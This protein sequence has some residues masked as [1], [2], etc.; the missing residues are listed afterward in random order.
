LPGTSPVV[1]VVPIP[2]GC[3]IW[4]VMVLSET[5]PFAAYL[6]DVCSLTSYALWIHSQQPRQSLHM[7]HTDY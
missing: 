3:S 1:M 5:L 4:H 7:E 2:G 6:L